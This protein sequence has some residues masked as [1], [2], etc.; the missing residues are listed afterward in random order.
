VTHALVVGAGPNG[1]AAAIML[2]EAGR[3]VRVYEAADQVGGGTRTEELTLPGFLHDVCSA[4]HPFGIAS[5]VFQRFQLE[6]HGLDWAFS[7]VELAHPF[8]DGSVALLKRS[9]Q[10]TGESLG[11]DGQA[12]GKLMQPFVDNADRLLNAMLYPHD[13]VKNPLLMARFGLHAIRSA[14]G[15]V[16]AYFTEPHAR[17]L[18]AGIAAHSFLRMDQSPSAALGLVLGFMGHSH[19]WPSARGGSQAIAGA[20]AAH[21]RSLGGEIVTGNRVDSFDDLPDA[22]AVL[23]DVTPRQLIRIAGHRFPDGYRRR[24]SRFRY[25][26]GAFKMDFALDGPIPWKAQ[27][28]LQAATVHVGGTFEEIAEAEA[29]VIAGKHPE[30]PFVLVAQQSL[31][32]NSRAPDGKHTVW[33]YCHVPNGSTVDM[34]DQ[35]ESQIER[36]APG[37]GDRILARSV[38]NTSDLQQHNANYIGGD[39]SGG[40]LDLRQL[41]TRPVVRIPPYT[42]PDKR[43]YLCSASTPPGGGV[44]GICG[45]HAA[46]AALRRA[47]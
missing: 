30:R 20:L 45:F 9:I 22:G 5:P 39:I 34:S 15:L 25:G 4:I 43:I 33:A 12:W 37:F 31:F 19:G 3:S 14:K 35:I 27:E 16:N 26:P 24:L 8:D 32:D 29:A 21:L 1:M 13:G 46:R 11:A 18:F 40:F 28:C 47:W 2:A 44:H 7:P 23:F 41:F 38:M 42:T 36:F 17:G 6:Q 10:E